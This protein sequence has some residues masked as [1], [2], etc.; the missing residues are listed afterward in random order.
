MPPAPSSRSSVYRSASEAASRAEESVI[1]TDPIIGSPLSRRAD[2]YLHPRHEHT[3]AW[4]G[5]ERVEHRIAAHSPG[6]WSLLVCV[7]AACQPSERPFAISDSHPRQRCGVRRAPALQH[8]FD[9]CD[10]L[11]C[12]IITL[13][14]RECRGAYSGSHGNP[15][16]VLSTT[17]QSLRCREC[18]HRRVGIS[19]GDECRR[20]VE[21][22]EAEEGIHCTCAMSGS[23]C[24]GVSV[25]II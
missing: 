24:L 5:L 10:L 15:L 3:E 13:Q 2:V 17:I 21:I 19:H 6:C 18:L 23:D 16:L 8:G 20:V 7:D 11:A 25:F 14:T 4:I 12:L 1:H 9:N 22:R